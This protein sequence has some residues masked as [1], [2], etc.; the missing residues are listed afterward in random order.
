[1]VS[2]EKELKA[3]IAEDM[4][5]LKQDV[6]DLVKDRKENQYSDLN[7]GIICPKCKN[8]C[9]GSKDSRVKGGFRVRKK[10]CAYCGR[11]WQTIE[12]VY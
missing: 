12:I 6:E 9:K 11:R 10:V 3:M 4:E 8:I 7:S 5:R 1:M 2:Y